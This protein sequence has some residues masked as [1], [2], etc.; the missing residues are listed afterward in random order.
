MNNLKILIISILLLTLGCSKDDSDVSLSEFE[1]PIITGYE[2]RTIQGQK[3]SNYG[4][5]NIKLGN[6]SNNY[7]SEYFFISYP[8]PCKNRCSVY[9]KSPDTNTT[10]YVWIVQAQY[11]DYNSN[12]STELGSNIMHVGGVPL[13]ETETT[14]ENISFDVS[15]LSEGYYRIYL[16]IDDL[17]L[18]DNLV[19][20]NNINL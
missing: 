11:R 8:N 1:I 4:I 12:I 10:K 18:Y 14:Y 7:D 5:P 20:T 3:I 2:L 9:I 17:I 13:I 16:K 19:I 6:E 15:S